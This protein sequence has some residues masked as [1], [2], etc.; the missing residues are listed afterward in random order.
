MTKYLN[1]LDSLE[2]LY[3]EWLILCCGDEIHT[4]EGLQF[5][6]EKRHRLDEFVVWVKENLE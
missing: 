5:A 4:D 2:E 1:L 3:S 6:V